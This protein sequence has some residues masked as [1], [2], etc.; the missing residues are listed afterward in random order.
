MRLRDDT[1][2]NV[3]DIL[4][5]LIRRKKLTSYKPD[6]CKEL[7]LTQDAD[8][9]IL[10][11]VFEDTNSKYEFEAGKWMLE[12]ERLHKHDVCEFI[13]ELRGEK[14]DLTTKAAQDSYIQDFSQNRLS[15]YIIMYDDDKGMESWWNKPLGNY[16]E[17][18]FEIAEGDIG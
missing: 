10:F 12:C 13:K 4:N 18:L 14:I 7:H 9:F 6:T 2:F 15:E 16:T 8:T 1:L 5:D 3:T 17:C 11:R